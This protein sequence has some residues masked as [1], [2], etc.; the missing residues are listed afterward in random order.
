MT[1]R[2]PSLTLPDAHLTNPSDGWLQYQAVHLL[3]ERAAATDTGFTIT[4]DNAATVAAVCRRLDG[5]PLAIELAA[6]RLTVLSIEQIHARLDDR[7][8][9][10]AQAHRTPIERQRTLEA[11]VD[12]SYELLSDAERRLLRR[13]SPFAGGWTLEAAEVVCSGEGIDREDVLDLMARLVDKSLVMVDEEL[14]GHR[15]YRY[16]ETVRQY[17][18][19]RL[20]QSGESDVVRAR[21]F[22]FFLDLTRRA[23]PQLVKGE[24]LRWLGRLQAEHDNLRAGLE[25]CLASESRC[26]ES[27]EMAGRLHWFWL[28]RAY[29]A[30][31]QQWLERVLAMSVMASAGQRAQALAALGSLVFFQGDFARAQEL[32]QESTLRAR[33]ARVPAIAGL[34]LG[35]H[36]MAAMESGDLAGAARLA[37][38]SAA[39]AREAT[40]PWLQLFSLSFFAY[41]ALFAGAIVGTT[42][43]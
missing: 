14:D 10:L 25:W 6:A 16:L 18:W 22:A 12:W 39:A 37:A 13:L 42:D 17:A 33:E 29:L 30:E 4:A 9:L 19:E 26:P 20:R 41:E 15:R 2:V 35:L 31:G 36:T 1:W 11:T 23:E 7:F 32:L 21:H 40:E 28:K 24:Q 5:I 27:V 43:P 3:V 34:A 8:R 38:E